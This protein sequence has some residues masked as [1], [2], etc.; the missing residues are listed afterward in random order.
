MDRDFQFTKAAPKVRG[1][2]LFPT[3][4]SKPH[5]RETNNECFEIQDSTLGIS[6]TSEDI[7]ERRYGVKE[8]NRIYSHMELYNISFLPMLT[9]EGCHPSVITTATIVIKLS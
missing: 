9:S 1:T 5:K 6:P 7:C 3:S 8:L 2:V 4:V